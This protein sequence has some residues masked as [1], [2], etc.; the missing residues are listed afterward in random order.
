MVGGE[1]RTVVRPSASF[2]HRA[3]ATLSSRI[4]LQPVAVY[5]VMMSKSYDPRHSSW[6]L[7]SHLDANLV[8]CR[9]VPQA[10]VCFNDRFDIM[11]SSRR[12][13]RS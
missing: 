11:G 1:P 9:R 4:V 10:G 2:P 12:R 8:K 5:E 13:R 7:L 6:L 3:P